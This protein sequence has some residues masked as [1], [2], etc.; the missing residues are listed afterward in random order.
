MTSP[1]FCAHLVSIDLDAAF[2]CQ[3]GQGFPMFPTAKQLTIGEF[4]KGQF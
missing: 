4:D 2:R 3:V 1:A